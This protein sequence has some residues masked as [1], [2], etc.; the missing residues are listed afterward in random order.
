[1]QM[2]SGGKK[3]ARSVEGSLGMFTT[4]LGKSYMCPSP[5]VINLFESKSGK[6]TVVVRLANIQIQAFQ[7]EKGK[8]APGMFVTFYCYIF[9]LMYIPI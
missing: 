6:Q 7:I 2:S 3:V 5:P 8:F 4:P 9:S 1:M